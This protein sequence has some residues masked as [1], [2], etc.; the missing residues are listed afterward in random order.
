MRGFRLFLES[1]G[2]SDQDIEAI[3]SMP[4]DK[5]KQ[6]INSK[7]SK[8]DF[9]NV[10]RKTVKKYAWTIPCKEYIES[11]KAHIIPNQPVY[12]V[13][14]GTGFVGKVLKKHGINVISSDAEILTKKNKYGHTNL[15]DPDMEE[16]DALTRVNSFSTPINVLMSW[17]PYSEDTDLK[18]AEILQP[19]SILIYVGES[20]GG[21][22]GSEEFWTYASKNFQVLDDMYIPQW[23]AIH[24]FLWIGKKLTNN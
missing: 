9:F 12:D 2:L 8:E 11:I 13:M 23:P 16:M 22:T 10:R 21:A 1:E 24:D 5:V 17:V 7:T 14:A 4:C 18:V 19:N 6:F 15:H 20:Y 3:T